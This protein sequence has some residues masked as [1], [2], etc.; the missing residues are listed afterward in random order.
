MDPL[1]MSSSS[2]IESRYLSVIN[3]LK[4]AKFNKEEYNHAFNQLKENGGL[5]ELAVT[6]DGFLVGTN[7]EG[8]FQ[9]FTPEQVNAG[10]PRKEGYSLL[11]NSNLLYLRANSP[12]AAFNH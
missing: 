8:D 6:S 12:N 3:R 2:D 7:A 1:G 11:T 9:Y 5:N 10:E 4:I